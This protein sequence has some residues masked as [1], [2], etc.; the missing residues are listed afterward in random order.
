MNK[1]VEKII[2]TLFVRY[3]NLKPC[4]ESVILAIELLNAAQALD[5]RKPMKTSPFL[6]HFLNQFRKKVPFMENDQ[7]M[8]EAIH[9]AISFLN[10]VEIKIN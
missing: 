6:Q 4:K 3:P 7:I 2:D 5:F 10:N 9:K 1:P 8:Y